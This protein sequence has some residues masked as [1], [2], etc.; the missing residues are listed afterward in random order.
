MKKVTLSVIIS[1]VLVLCL[2]S[3][4]VCASAAGVV[5]TNVGFFINGNR[6]SLERDPVAINGRILAP[7]RTVF[8]N[9][10]QG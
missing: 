4:C 8:A 10:G 5:T 1:V 3:L 6:I 9:F 7:A 2:G